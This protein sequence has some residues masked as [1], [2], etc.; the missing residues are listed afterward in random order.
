MCTERSPEYM[1]DAGLPKAQSCQAV[2]VGLPAAPV[3]C[4]EAGFCSLCMRQELLAYLR[5]DFEGG[6]RNCRTEPRDYPLRRYI[7][8][9]NRLFQDTC[10]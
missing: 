9:S 1:P 2:Q 3:V 6:L 8:S 5:A 4:R 7:H 10:T